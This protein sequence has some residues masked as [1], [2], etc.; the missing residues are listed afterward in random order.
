MDVRVGSGR[1]DAFV[2]WSWR[3]FLRVPWTAWRAK[4]SILKE[5]NPEYSLAGLMLKL[6]SLATWC[7]E[8]THWK[9]PWCRER[10]RARRERRDR[11]W[12]SWMASPTQWTWHSVRWWRTEKPGM[13]QFMLRSQRVRH[14]LATASLVAQTVKC[15]PT[16]QETQ[17]WSLGQQ[18]PLE[19]EMATHSRIL[20]WKIPWME[21]PGRL[22]SMGSQRVGQNWAT[23]LHFPSL[24]HCTM[25]RVFKNT[26]REQEGLPSLGETNWS[27]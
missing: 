9:R 25:A 7:E 22:Q 12:D 21:E 16:M 15:L 20:A 6:Q 23:S 24:R 18:V 4:Q 27:F 17:V 13:L 19:R 2:L 11:E 26:G 1:T 8:P 10:L 14:D 3:R 5:I